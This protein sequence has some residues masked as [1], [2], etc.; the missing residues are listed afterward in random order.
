MPANGAHPHP[1]ELHVEYGDE[2]L[3]WGG[4]GMPRASPGHPCTQLRPCGS[5]TSRFTTSTTNSGRASRSSTKPPSKPTPRGNT[6]PPQQDL[7][8]VTV[9]SFS[10]CWL[11]AAQRAAC[12][13]WDL[14]GS[15][16]FMGI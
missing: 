4:V 1:P 10:W 16:V 2:V 6:P 11:K 5:L 13:Q 7:D 9:F 8:H 3:L 12:A 14:P 15:C